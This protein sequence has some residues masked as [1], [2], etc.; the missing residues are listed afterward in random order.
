MNVDNPLKE[1]MKLLNGDWVRKYRF[2][3]ENEAKARALEYRAREC[4]IRNTL[5]E[6]D[7]GYWWVT[8]THGAKP[9]DIA[10]KYITNK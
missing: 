9:G 1:W 3:E 7:K 8:L 6:Y 4:G 2:K 10:S 5:I